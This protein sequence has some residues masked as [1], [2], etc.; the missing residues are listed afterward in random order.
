MKNDV[1]C[2]QTASN[3]FKQGSLIKLDA[4]LYDMF[5]GFLFYSALFGLV[6]Y[7]TL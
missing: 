2:E 3:L 6:I 5:L 7:R 1:K 4:N